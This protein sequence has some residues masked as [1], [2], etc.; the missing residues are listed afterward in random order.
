VIA[1]HLHLHGYGY[2]YVTAYAHACL[3]D[4]LNGMESYHL[5]RHAVVALVGV[6]VGGAA[7]AVVVLV[8][9]AVQWIHCL[10]G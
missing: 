3:T 2:M 7:A 8:A 1:L 6:E 9:V 10:F 5:M 4:A